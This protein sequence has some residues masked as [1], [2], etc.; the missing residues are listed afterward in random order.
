LLQRLPEQIPVLLATASLS[1]ANDV[2][3]SC[4]FMSEERFVTEKSPLLL[5][6]RRERVAA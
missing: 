4:V 3:I 2:V 6:V 1:L 5:N